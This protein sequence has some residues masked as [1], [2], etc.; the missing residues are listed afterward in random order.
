MPCHDWEVARGT[1]YRWNEAYK[2]C[3]EVQ[4]CQHCEKSGLRD[5]R[6]G[7]VVIDVK[8]VATGGLPKF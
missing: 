2:V 4:A 3:W 5:R 6:K 7:L 1:V 8:A